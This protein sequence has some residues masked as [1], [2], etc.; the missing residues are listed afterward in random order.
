MSDSLEI[1]FV[2]FF[3]TDAKNPSYKTTKRFLMIMLFDTSCFSK[4]TLKFHCFFSKRKEKVFKQ[5]EWFWYITSKILFA[6]VWY[7]HRC[8]FD[9][10]KIF[11]IKECKKKI[12]NYWRLT[13]L[14][15]QCNIFF[16]ILICKSKEIKRGWYTFFFHHFY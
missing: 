6:I 12:Y 8:I 11:Y 14:S 1:F 3:A 7:D 16:L 5:W 15:Y 2:I 4:F 13:H 10:H 9:E